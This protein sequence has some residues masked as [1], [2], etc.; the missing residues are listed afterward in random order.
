M[1]RL[2]LVTMVPLY[3]GYL[4][5]GRKTLT[6]GIILQEANCRRKTAFTFTVTAFVS[7]VRGQVHPGRDETKL[8]NN[9]RTQKNCCFVFFGASFAADFLKIPLPT[10]P[11]TE[12]IVLLTGETAKPHLGSTSITKCWQTKKGQN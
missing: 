6:L 9:E 5:K 11:N 10:H 7:G 8:K 4:K 12:G 2:P 1:V 3:S